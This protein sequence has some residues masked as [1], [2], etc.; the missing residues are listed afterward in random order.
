MVFEQ[1]KIESVFVFK[2]NVFSDHRGFFME[3]YRK[4]VFS[5]QGLNFEFVQDN[6]SK[7]VKGTLRGLHFQWEPPMGKLMRVTKGSAFL[8][9]VDIRKDSATLGEWFGIEV[10]EENKIQVFAPA[11]C[12]R[13]FLA[14]SDETE[15]QY[16]CTGIYNQNAESGIKWDDPK[17]GI[18]WPIED[19][20]LSEKDKKQKTLDEWLQ[21]PESENFK[22]ELFDV[23]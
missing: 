1:Q 16:K 21:S 6:H 9:A 18:K 3:T 14:L 8:V 23:E 4:D 17:I 11:G 22:M 19:Q 2:P 12:A 15:I 10:S 13:G 5:E 7:S 20:I